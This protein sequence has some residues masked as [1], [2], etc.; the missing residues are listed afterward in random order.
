MRWVYANNQLMQWL[1]S[2]RATR[3]SYG[4]ENT[5]VPEGE[6]W[7]NF[8]VRE[9]LFGLYRLSSLTRIDNNGAKCGL[10]LLGAFAEQ[11]RQSMANTG[12]RKLGRQSE[13]YS[14]PNEHQ[15]RDESWY[16]N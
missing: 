9:S 3:N 2:W 5:D 16:V 12:R 6:S 13:L 4:T 11:R 1:W 14:F 10:E 7:W 8:I 15:R